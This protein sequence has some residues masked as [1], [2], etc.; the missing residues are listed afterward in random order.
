MKKLFATCLLTVTMGTLGVQAVRAPHA[1]PS[2]S[3]ETATLPVQVAEQELVEQDLVAEDQDPSAPAKLAAE[4]ANGQT[5]ASATQGIVGAASAPTAESKLDVAGKRVTVSSLVGRALTDQ[6]Q[7]LLDRQADL[8][9]WDAAAQAHFAKWFGTTRPEAR[10]LIY[11]R[12]RVLTLLNNEYSVGNFRRAVP[13][14][15]GLFAFVH[16]T[17]P[18]K[19]FVDQAFIFAPKIGE[20]SRAG[21]VTHEMS[22]FSLAGGTRDIQYGTSG[23]RALARSEPAKALQNADSF[24]FYVENVR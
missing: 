11:E 12:I 3:H 18:A 22:H 9:R 19:I 15:P 1:K 20:N 7:L 16:P 17:D 23:C 24:E 13:S 8:E 10:E 6:K 14:K 2:P 5:C 21:T 4:F